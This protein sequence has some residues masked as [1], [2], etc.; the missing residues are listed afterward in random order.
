M[1]MHNKL[2]YQYFNAD[3]QI[4]KEIQNLLKLYIQM[5]E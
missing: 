2:S 5:F 3:N 1:R 4:E